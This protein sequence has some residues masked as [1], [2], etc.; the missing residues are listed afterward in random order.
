[1]AVSGAAS[2][3]DELFCGWK[4]ALSIYMRGQGAGLE[5]RSFPSK[6][7]RK[8]G[9]VVGVRISGIELMKAVN[10]WRIEESLVR[11]VLLRRAIGCTTGEKEH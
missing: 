2:L 4:K 10:V 9:N 5:F 11:Q 3:P 1:M 6:G 8:A 7:K